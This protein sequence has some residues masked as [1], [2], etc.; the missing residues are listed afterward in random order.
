MTHIQFL[1]EVILSIIEQVNI[2]S[3]CD[4]VFNKNIPTILLVSN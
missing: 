2:W 1:I 3:M 4:F